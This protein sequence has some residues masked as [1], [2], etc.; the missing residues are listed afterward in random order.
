[1]YQVNRLA[2]GSPDRANPGLTRPSLQSLTS[3]LIGVLTRTQDRAFALI[4]AR[5]LHAAGLAG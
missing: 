3:A 4:D 2:K 5:D 1:M